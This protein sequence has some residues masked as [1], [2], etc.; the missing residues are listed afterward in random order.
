MG[1]EERSITAV[2]KPKMEVGI[3]YKWGFD[4]YGIYFGG[5][6][7]PGSDPAVDAWLPAFRNNLKF[8]KNDLGVRTLRIFLLCNAHN[9]GTVVRRP[10]NDDSYDLTLP[11]SLHPKFREHLEGMLQ[12]LATEGMRIIPSIIDFGAICSPQFG[13]NTA[14]HEVVDDAGKRKK[15][16]DIVVEPLLTWSKPFRSQILAWEVINEPFW[17]CLKRVFGHGFT[18]R[19]VSI[20]EM[21]VFINETLQRIH[22]HEFASTV[23]HRFRRDFTSVAS[24]MP[25]GTLR[26][27][28]YYPPLGALAKMLPFTESDLPPFKETNAFVGEFAVAGEG[29][30][31]AFWPDLDESLQQDARSRAFHRLRMLD[32]KGYL[33]ALTWSDIPDGAVGSS[34]PKLSAGAMEGIKDYQKL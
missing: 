3:N 21:T 31:G 2:P 29:S 28:H 34:D 15:F 25:T 14:R 13:G 12:A 4:K 9:L 26:Q 19:P 6:A 33:L 5:G 32:A 23:G 7:P 24:K 18:D 20:Q 11:T 30:Q 10:A 22:A 1:N 27:F 16:L 17:A 8:F